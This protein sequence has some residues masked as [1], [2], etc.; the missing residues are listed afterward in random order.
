MNNEKTVSYLAFEASEAR[1]E[2]KFKLLLTC[3]MII[4][5]ILFASNMAWLWLF[6]G[7]ISG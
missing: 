5:S 1:S 7:R 6:M 2:R 4:M 3:L